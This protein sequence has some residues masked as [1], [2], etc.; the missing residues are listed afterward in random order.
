MAGAFLERRAAL[1]AAAL[2]AISPLVLGYA[3]E[4]RAYVFLMLAC[5]IAVGAT[6]RA[7]QQA[8]GRNRRLA[9]GAAAAF[10]AIWLHY[11]AV[12]VILP[13][14]VW[15]GAASA[16]SRR[17]RL[18]FIAACVAGAA[19]VLPLLL[20]QYHYN[21]NGGAIAGAINWQNLV[22]VVGTPFTSRVGTPVNVRTVV[23]ALVVL[24]A[25]AALLLQR[26]ERV[27]HRGLLAALGA[28]GVVALIVVDLTGKHILITRYTTITAPFLITTVVAACV[29]LRR[30][31]AALLAIVAAAVSVAGLI[32]NHS[33]RQF[34]APAKQAVQ[35][36]SA[37]QRPHD[38]M[39]APGVPVTDTAL[40]YYVTHRTH[41]KLH[42]FGLLDPGVPHAFRTHERIW[43]VD[44]PRK[45]TD[46]SAL[47]AVSRLLHRFRWHSVT[48]RVYATSINLGVLLTV[49]DA[50]RRGPTARRAL[51]GA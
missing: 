32:D 51:H 31:H 5:V 34:Y 16:F 18:M 6:V 12:S 47:A 7:N 13:L 14:A 43:I 8:S 26:R 27:A 17:Q 1:G 20:E 45:P 3:Q 28:F 9:L 21:P 50:S 35:Y 25:V 37:H 24:A 2:C 30:A 29:Q 46:A 15:V 40:F 41:P 11:T 23:G 22:A 19:T 44:R 38:F 49:P 33:S 10:L 39:F 48:T 36:I 42:F 4:T